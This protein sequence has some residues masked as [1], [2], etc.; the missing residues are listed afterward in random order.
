M[1]GY[2]GFIFRDVEPVRQPHGSIPVVTGLIQRGDEAM[3]SDDWHSAE[4]CYTAAYFIK[5]GRDDLTRKKLGM[6]KEILAVHHVA[7]SANARVE[8]SR[9]TAQMLSLTLEDIEEALDT[10]LPLRIELP[11]SE[12][13]MEIEGH[14]DRVLRKGRTLQSSVQH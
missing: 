9:H 6:V 8:T 3:W 2:D 10:L 5:G 14:L 7:R 12:S 4:N 11:H 1:V 13:L